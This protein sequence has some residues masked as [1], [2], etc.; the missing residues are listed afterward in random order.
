M[1]QRVERVQGGLVRAQKILQACIGPVYAH[2]ETL[3]ALHQP[4]HAYNE[5]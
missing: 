4:L 1:Q 3:N 5:E 2:N